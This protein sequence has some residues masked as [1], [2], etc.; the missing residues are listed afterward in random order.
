VTQQN[1]D[2]FQHSFA[3]RVAP[4][5]SVLLALAALGGILLPST[6]ARETTTWAAQGIGQD[7]VNLLVVVPW[8][9]LSGLWAARGS[10]RAVLLLGGGLVYLVYGFL[11]YAFAVHFNALFLLY[12]AVLGLSFYALASLGGVL[13]DSTVSSWF[14][15][16]RIPWRLAGVTQL[17][18]VVMF[19][20]VW[21]SEVL[22][23]LLRG[24]PPPS[25]VEAGLLTNPVHVLDLSLL[26]PGLMLSGIS[27]LRRRPLGLALSPLLLGF[28]ALMVSAIGGMVLVMA[29]RRV[30]VQWALAVVFAVVAI[31]TFTVLA[32]LLAAV[33]ETVA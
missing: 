23:A 17:V 3:V 11:A 21:L 29:L 33:P 18:V 20:L 30:T 7:W 26:L 8:M 2:H 14:T 16:E 6:Y 1:E 4:A 13:H 10:R 12:C 27:L 22:P 9:A 24:T 25:V 32:K 28:A 15:A 19:A 31:A 5:L